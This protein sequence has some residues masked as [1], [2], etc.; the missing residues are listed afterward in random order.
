MPSVAASALMART[1]AASAAWVSMLRRKVRS[2]FSL[3]IGSWRR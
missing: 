3:S 2:I 1:M